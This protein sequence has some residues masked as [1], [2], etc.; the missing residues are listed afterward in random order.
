VEEI[1]LRFG[2]KENTVK[3]MLSRTRGRLRDYLR[4]E[5]IGV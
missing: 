1:A 4:K 3:T 2:M 5:G